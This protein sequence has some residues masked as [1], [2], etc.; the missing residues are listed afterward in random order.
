MDFCNCSASQDRKNQVL[1][2]K[3]IRRQNQILYDFLHKISTR[4]IRENQT[5][6]LEDLN[7]SGMLKNRKL[8]RSIADASW[9]TFVQYLKYKS[10]WYGTNLLFIGRFEPSSK[11]CS[12]GKINKELQLSDR[13][14]TCES[15][16]ATHD[17]DILAARNIKKF[18]L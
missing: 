14:W 9:S 3:T 6:I 4:L 17:R 15:C 18:G 2:L 1:E 8:S 7:V 10:E 13:E 16:E 12:C 11:M 5:I